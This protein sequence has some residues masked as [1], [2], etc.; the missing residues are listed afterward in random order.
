MNR[1]KGNIV[2][3]VVVVVVVIILKQM[4]RPWL[5]IG[6]KSCSFD[7]TI[8]KPFTLSI[9]SRRIKCAKDYRLLPTNQRGRS[10]QSHGITS[11][12]LSSRLVTFYWDLAPSISIKDKG[13]SK[14][15]MY[16]DIFSIFSLSG[17]LAFL[18]SSN[19]VGYDIGAW[20]QYYG[21]TSLLGP[22]YTDHPVP[23][24][25]LQ[26]ITLSIAFVHRLDAFI[27]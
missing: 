12:R 19:A 21:M 14:S 20:R 4:C 17:E 25:F 5:I 15:V 6:I 11:N 3:V 26:L 1:N 18:I 27:K 24:K 13:E 7:C 16:S 9:W 23:L 2:V 8:N 10:I 22:V